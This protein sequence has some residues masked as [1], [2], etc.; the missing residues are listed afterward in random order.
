M[1]RSGV[2]GVGEKENALL[3]MKVCSRAYFMNYNNRLP[4]SSFRM[5]VANLS[6]FS[7]MVYTE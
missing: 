5:S 4:N 7:E 6:K 1:G 3:Q 2:E